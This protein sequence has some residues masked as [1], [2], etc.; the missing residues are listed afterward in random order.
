LALD[1][2]EQLLLL[3]HRHVPGF[4]GDINPGERHGEN[5]VDPAYGV[6]LSLESLSFSSIA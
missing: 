4:T 5:A 2:S 6:P 1:I 3:E